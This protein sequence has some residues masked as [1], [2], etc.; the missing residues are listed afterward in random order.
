MLCEYQTSA[1]FQPAKGAI[2]VLYSAGNPCRRL[3]GWRVE[4]VAVTAMPH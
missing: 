1:I 4:V 3:L 2:L